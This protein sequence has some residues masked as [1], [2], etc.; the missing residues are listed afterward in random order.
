MA[1]FRRAGSQHQCHCKNVAQQTF[2]QP[3]TNKQNVILNKTYAISKG[4]YREAKSL[5]WYYL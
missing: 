4:R 3:V 1:V 2:E 5:Q